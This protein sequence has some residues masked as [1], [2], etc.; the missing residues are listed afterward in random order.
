[1]NRKVATSFQDRHIRRGK[2]PIIERVH[3][4]VLSLRRKGRSCLVSREAGEWAVL[5]ALASILFGVHMCQVGVCAG[6]HFGLFG[7]LS[8]RTRPVLSSGVFVNHSYAGKQ[9]GAQ[10]SEILERWRGR[11]KS[12]G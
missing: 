10:K 1:M 6:I 8:L 5:R 2:R 7:L 4:S 11:K 9:R 3:I 12:S